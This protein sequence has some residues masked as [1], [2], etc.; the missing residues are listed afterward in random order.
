MVKQVKQQS[1]EILVAIHYK[2]TIK[3]HSFIDRNAISYKKWL[4]LT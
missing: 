1:Q 2:S 4:S 3:I